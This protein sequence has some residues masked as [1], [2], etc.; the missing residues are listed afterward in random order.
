MHLEVGF[1]GPCLVCP[2]DRGMLPACALHISMACNTLWKLCKREVSC[3]TRGRGESW[4]HLRHCRPSYI[5][6][7]KCAAR[8]LL[9]TCGSR[10]PLV[11]ILQI[12][13][14][15]QDLTRC[16]VQKYTHNSFT[17]LPDNPALLIEACPTAR[18]TFQ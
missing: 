9:L 6:M 16:G 8:Q 18:T 12:I 10:A 13:V 4:S 17:G 7:V 3:D 14:I 2:A 1:A 11:P 5:V 15:R